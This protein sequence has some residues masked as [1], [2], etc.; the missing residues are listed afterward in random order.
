MRES[1]QG[2]DGIWFAVTAN[3]IAIG[4]GLAFAAH[5]PCHPPRRMGFP[6]AMLMMGMAFAAVLGIIVAVPFSIS[7]LIRGDRIWGLI[8]LGLGLLAVP[9]LTLAS[10][11]WFCT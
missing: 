3:V 9:M 11:I 4:F 5:D 6:E 7:D 8:G 1:P 10:G 2:P